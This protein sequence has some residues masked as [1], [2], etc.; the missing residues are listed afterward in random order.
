VG[1]L[2]EDDTKNHSI[3]LVSSPPEKP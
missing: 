1:E 3:T 2:S